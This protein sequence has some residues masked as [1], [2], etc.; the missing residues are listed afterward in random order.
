M[1]ARGHFFRKEI[2]QEFLYH[3]VDHLTSPEGTIIS[4]YVGFKIVSTLSQSD[5]RGIVSIIETIEQEMYM[6][7]YFA[8]LSKDP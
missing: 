2:T 4:L 8:E 3:L 7:K 6:T 5:K 1:D